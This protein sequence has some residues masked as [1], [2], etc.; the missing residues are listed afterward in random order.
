[1]ASNQVATGQNDV[2]Q[3]VVLAVRFFHAVGHQVG[4]DHG[5]EAQAALGAIVGRTEGIQQVLELD[6]GQVVRGRKDHRL[7]TVFL[8]DVEHVPGDEIQRFLPGGFAEHAFAALAHP[9]QRGQN[10]VGVVGVHQAGL[11]ARAELAVRM[12]VIGIAFQLDDAAIFDLGQQATAPDAH[13]AHAGNVAAI[14]GI[15][16]TTGT[17][18][19]RDCRRN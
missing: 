18:S 11:A 7:R 10:S 19:F 13:L 4:N 1:M 9:D 12:R 3:S 8:L 17:G 15:Q 5:V 6:L 16:Q 2:L 14:G